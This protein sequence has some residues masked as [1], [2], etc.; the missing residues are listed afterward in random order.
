MEDMKLV[1]NIISANLV[2][3][4]PYV[5]DLVYYINKRSFNYAILQKIKRF[6]RGQRL[7]TNGARKLSIED[8]IKLCDFYNVS[9]DYIIG[10]TDNIELNNSTTNIKYQIQGGN[11]YGKITMK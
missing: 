3:V 7:E 6:K 11:N 5:T 2:I 8:L 10:R 4:K 1:T 9:A